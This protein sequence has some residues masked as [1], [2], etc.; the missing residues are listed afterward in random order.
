MDPYQYA[1]GETHGDPETPYPAMRLSSPPRGRA[2]SNLALRARR[3][4]TDPAWRS[5]SE[6]SKRLLTEIDRKD[7]RR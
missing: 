6:E 1:S 4:K 5:R 3:V 2:T 7:A